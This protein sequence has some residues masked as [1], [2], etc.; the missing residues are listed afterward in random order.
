M[1][2]HFTIHKL[3]ILAAVWVHN[4]GGIVMSL[5]VVNWVILSKGRFQTGELKKHS[6]FFS[7]KP[8]MILLINNNIYFPFPALDS[9]TALPA[10]FCLAA[11]LKALPLES[12]LCN[13]MPRQRWGIHCSMQWLTHPWITPG[14][15]DPFLLQ[16]LKELPRGRCLIMWPNGQDE[17]IEFTVA[18][19]LR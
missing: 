1:Q 13:V 9:L 5:D 18:M 6:I 7:T 2:S 4:L 8:N 17:N 15:G 14:D 16:R 10:F 12:S 3:L 19:I 11:M